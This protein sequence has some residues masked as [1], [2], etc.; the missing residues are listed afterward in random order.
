VFGVTRS[1]TLDG[2][3]F[4]KSLA[5]FRVLF[6]RYGGQQHLGMSEPGEPLDTTLSEQKAAADKPSLPVS[7]RR[8][9]ARFVVWWNEAY[10]N[11]GKLRDRLLI[12]AGAIYVLGYVTWSVH[13][14]THQLGPLPAVQG[15]YFVAGLVIAIIL[16]SIYM[17]VESIIRFRL[18]LGRHP[19]FSVLL[20]LAGVAL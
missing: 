15:Q 6:L 19:I 8:W 4:W 12:A 1:T 20:A 13:A 2:Q 7:R 9:L 10:T 18:K 3:T 14:F 17:V 16:F 11:P 5:Q